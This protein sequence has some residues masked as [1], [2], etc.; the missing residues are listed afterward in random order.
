[1]AMK[2]E[3]LRP[4]ASPAPPGRVVRRNCCARAARWPFPP[5]TVYG[6]GA[7]ALDSMAVAKIFSAKG[8]PAWDPLI[9]H[10]DSRRMLDTVAVLP[11]ELKRSARAA[12]VRVLAGAADTAA[13]SGRAGCHLRSPRRGRWLRSASRSIRWR[14]SSSV[15][16]ECRWLRPVPTALDTP[17]LPPQPTC[18]PIS[19]DASTPFSDGG[20]ATVGVESTVFDVAARVIYRPGAVTPQ[21]I[22]DVIGG[23]VRVLRPARSRRRL[24]HNL[25]HRGWRIATMRRGPGWCSLPDRRS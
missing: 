1:M 14:W 5:K 2:T 17:A 6:L 16:P 9:V 20:A 4:A 23:Q 22:S 11:Q 21:M 7:N 3:R 13:A 10:V 12:D 19:T 24:R 15:W 18:S 25:L 8:R